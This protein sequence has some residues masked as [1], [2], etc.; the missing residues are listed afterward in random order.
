MA[1]HRV[2]KIDG[3][4]ILLARQILNS[5]IMDKPPMFLKLWVWMLERAHH[6][7]GHKGLK[8]GQFL[9][10]VKEMQD[11]MTHRVGARIVRP[12]QYRFLLQRYA[13]GKARGALCSSQHR[14]CR[15]PPG[16]FLESLPEISEK[17]ILREAACRHCQYKRSAAAS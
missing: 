10:S 4:Y 8:R 9:T 14:I 13:Q 15:A 11:A 5:K 17:D 7:N 2:E 16:S 1:E 6:K 3:G 12:Y